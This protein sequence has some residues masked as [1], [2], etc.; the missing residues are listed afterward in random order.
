MTCRLLLVTCN[1]GW[2]PPQPGRPAAHLRVYLALLPSGPDAVRRLKL[3]RLRAAVRLT[4]TFSVAYET[5]HRDTEATEE[6]PDVP[7]VS[8]PRR[9][10][11]RERYRLIQ[12]ESTDE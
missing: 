3:H 12:N 10:V 5:T 8:M 6:N 4:Q 7:G 2:A 11:I 9:V 1:F